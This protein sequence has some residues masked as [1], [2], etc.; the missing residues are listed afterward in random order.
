MTSLMAC[1]LIHGSLGVTTD[2]L[3]LRV[4]H[5][6]LLGSCDYLGRLKPLVPH[7]YPKLHSHMLG[8]IQH[9][10]HQNERHEIAVTDSLS[11]A[12]VFKFPAQYAQPYLVHAR[13]IFGSTEKPGYRLTCIEFL[14][15]YGTPS[16]LA[17]LAGT[18]SDE[19]FRVDDIASHWRRTVISASKGLARI[20]TDKKLTA[21]E[22]FIKTIPKNCSLHEDLSESR[23]KLHARLERSGE[24]PK[25]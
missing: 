11:L 20:G 9:N 25:K 1:V 10:I 6:Y 5:T 22:N 24:K 13:N 17:L 12:G 8:H 18:F 21:L 2:F 16:D 4:F 14:E 19:R 15:Q 3:S 23:E 7:L